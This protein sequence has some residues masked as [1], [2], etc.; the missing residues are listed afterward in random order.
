MYEY[1]FGPTP[2]FSTVYQG[3]ALDAGGGTLTGAA[4]G[5]GVPPPRD[6]DGQSIPK[7]RRQ[8][9]PLGK[10][11]AQWQGW[12]RLNQGKGAAVP[13]AGRYT[14]TPIPSAIA[15]ELAET[16]R[17]AVRMATP[18]IKARI[19]AGS[20]NGGFILALVFQPSYLLYMA[21][22]YTWRRSD[23]PHLHRSC[24]QRLAKE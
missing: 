18:L 11:P 12:Y 20:R 22:S 19:S 5:S 24:K 3:G 8:P 15:G 7:Q 21:D 10:A 6:D 1:T 2:S 23:N 16:Q 17:A 4:A 13:P 9:A 14:T